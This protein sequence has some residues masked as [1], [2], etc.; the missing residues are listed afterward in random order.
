MSRHQS[1]DSSASAQEDV[2]S[3]IAVKIKSLGRMSD[4]D[5]DEMIKMA[6]ELGEYLS[7]HE[8]DLKTSQIRRFSDAVKKIESQA[9]N[10]R[11]NFNRN[12]LLL[13]KP[14]IAYATGRLKEGKKNPLEPFQKVIDPA[15]DKV[16]DCDDFFRFAQF[17]ESIIAY[18][19]FHGG[20]EN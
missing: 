11:D 4:L 3:R 15:I 5:V 10:N 14:K 7:S 16:R 6:N 2:A 8:V 1:R 20:R 17:M 12:S 19:R 13:L 18:H 9:K